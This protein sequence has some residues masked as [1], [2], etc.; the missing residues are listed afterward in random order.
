M[1]IRSRFDSCGGL[2]AEWAATSHLPSS[3]PRQ[4]YRNRWR[5]GETGPVGARGRCWCSSPSRRSARHSGRHGNAAGCNAVGWLPPNAVWRRWC[6]GGSEHRR[7]DGAVRCR[8]TVCLP[9][10]G[11]ITAGCSIMGGSAAC[12]GGAD[13]GTNVDEV[14][15]SESPCGAGPGLGRRDR[16][17]ASG[18]VV[19]QHNTRGGVLG[20]Q[21]LLDAL[22]GSATTCRRGRRCSRR[23]DA[24]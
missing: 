11:C 9:N 13:G 14:C 3:G 4:I 12:A 20:T 6:A 24:C 5:S 1:S 8:R 19:A 10:H 16:R 2:C 15:D 17:R 7:R 22:E 23:S 18:W 21:R